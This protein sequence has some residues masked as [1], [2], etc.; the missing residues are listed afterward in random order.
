M[1]ETDLDSKI[2]E[3][4]RKV[5]AYNPGANA[6]L[7]DKAMRFSYN[8]LHDKKRLSG[9]DFFTHSYNVAMMLADLRRGS[10]TIATG[11][12]LPVME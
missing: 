7:I 6:A 9:E 4:L 3:L 1:T 5:K 11:L 8:A 10:H 2:E 12:L